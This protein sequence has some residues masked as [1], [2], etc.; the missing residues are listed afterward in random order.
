MVVKKRNLEIATT[1]L[2]G[3]LF[4]WIKA[5]ANNF[6]KLISFLDKYHKGIF[7]FLILIGVVIIGYLISKEVISLNE[8]LSFISNKF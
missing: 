1:E 3:A 8:I 4:E 5:L 2:I 6:I 7:V